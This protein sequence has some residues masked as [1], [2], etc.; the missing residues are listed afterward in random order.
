MRS[1]SAEARLI[2]NTRRNFVNY[3]DVTLYDG[4][5]LHLKPSDFRISG[6]NFTDDWCDGETFQLGSV[7]GK[8]ATIL[9]DNT[10]GRKEDFYTLQTSQPADWSTNF[11][12]YY[13]KDGKTY[14]PVPGTSVPTWTA[15]T[16]YTKTTETYLHGKFSE[17]DFYMSYF[18]LYIHLPD[19]VHI[20]GVLEDT[21]I[22]IGTFTV[23]TPASHG[24]TIEIT[25]VDNM[26][27]FDRSFDECTLD[28]NNN[29]NGRTLLEI[30][31]RCCHDC[32]VAIGYSQ[33]FLN[34]DMRVHKKPSGVTYR[35]VVS[36]IVQIA[37][38]N[39]KISVSGALTFGWYNMAPFYQEWYD[40]GSF[41]TNT[42][43]YSDGDTADGG[44]FNPW[45]TGAVIDG[46]K[47]TDNLNFHNLTATNGTTI[48][49]DDIQFTGLMVSYEVEVD[50][51]TET[52]SL[53]YPNV[54]NWDDY[55]MQI[56]GNPFIENAAGANRVATTV[57][58]NIKELKFRVFSCQSIQDPTIE[59]GD[60]ALVYDVKGNSYTTIITNVAF[61]TGG[62]TDVSCKAESPI[63]QNQRYVN[64]AA[65]AVAKSKA[66][67]DAYNAQVA[68]FNELAYASTGYYKTTSG[69]ITYL[70]DQPTL[71]ASTN[72]VKV[73]GSGAFISTDGGRSYNAGVDVSTATMLMNLIYVRGIKA[74]WINVDTLEAISAYMGNVVVGGNNNTNGTLKVYPATGNTPSVTLD[75]AGITASAG[76]IGGSNGWEILSG[77][78]H[79]KGGPTNINDTSKAGT[80]LGAGTNGILNI[81]N[82]QSY[83]KIQGGKITSNNVDLT[84]DIKANKGKI[85]GNGGWDIQTGYMR[86]PASGPTSVDATTT[87]GTYIGSGGIMNSNGTNYIKLKNGTLTAKNVDIDGG[88]INV[89][90]GKFHV[91]SSGKMTCTNA[92]I[93]GEVQATSGYIGRSGT[94][95][96]TIDNT[97]IY[98]GLDRI[99]GTDEATMKQTGTCISATYG[100]R[101]QKY[102]GLDWRN[103]KYV[104]MA[105][106]V[107]TANS[108]EIIGGTL[109][110]LTVENGNKGLSYN[111]DD[112]FFR[113]TAYDGVTCGQSINGSWRRMDYVDTKGLLKVDYANSPNSELHGIVVTNIGNNSATNPGSHYT[114]MVFDTFWSADNGEVAYN[115]SDE[116]I[117]KN[118]EDL[119]IEEA[120]E[121]IN[122]VRPRKFEFIHLEGTRYGF[123]AQELREVL[124]DNSGIEYVKGPEGD[125]LHNVSY[126]DFIAPLCMLVKKQQAEIDEL[127]TEVD[128]LKQRLEKLESIVNTKL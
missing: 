51:S 23:T 97:Y 27:M 68:H 6:N 67:M 74:D 101:N 37:G 28:F 10:D 79:S 49:T 31:N 72:V 96:W 65:K 62:M 105:E 40:G 103:T 71:A 13:I 107:L 70:H 94:A 52:R 120:E 58:D 39:A 127:K 42:T 47:F 95:G 44:N 117:K 8:T 57:W 124:D 116:R 81:T 30:L 114:Q 16:Y 87:V 125:E 77:Y 34:N 17:Y 22:S 60:C 89:N 80:Y 99:Y 69:N 122:S 12:D 55:A 38:C 64:P 14:I 4:T 112:H 26:Y 83:T 126:R 73:T 106:G 115:G 113:I 84:G 128:D 21:V 41:S 91:E 54:A 86:T 50:G 7:I 93:T 118:I 25:G 78:I 5:V 19:S 11:N 53:H 123:I 45:N 61:K 100:I 111:Q 15:N 46:G 2:M 18:E 20:L 104:R 121:L 102:D 9:L 33:T 98:N 24:A 66:E 92:K 3:A 119:T 75:K 82:A 63:A 1:I 109:A 48:S 59:A 35:E 36:Y 108:V 110:G 56:E 76:Y 29:S 90:N 88:D 43:P 32:G 85:G